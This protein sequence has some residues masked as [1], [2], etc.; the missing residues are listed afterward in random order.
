MHTKSIVV[1]LLLALAAVAAWFVFGSGASP[2]LP[3]AATPHVE[4]VLQAPDAADANTVGSTAGGAPVATDAAATE[5]MLVPPSEATVVAGNTYRVRGRLVDAQGSP[6]TN[7]RVRCH[8]WSVDGLVEDSKSAANPE[9]TSAADGVFAFDVPHGRN[10]S[11]TLADDDLVFANDGRVQFESGKGERD[12]GDLVVVRTARLKGVVQDELGRPVAGVIVDAADG[13]LAFGAVSRSKSGADG[14]FS[15]GKLRPGAWRVRAA[16]AQFL[17]TTLEVALAA[18]EQ[19]DDLVLVVRRGQAIAGQVVDDR[20]VGV[21]GCKVGSK[22]KETSGTMAIERFSADE[23]TTTDANGFFT[24]AGLGEGTATIRAFGAGHTGATAADVPIGTGNLVL[25]VQR[26]AVV[27]GVLVTAAGEPIAGS[28]VTAE[29]ERGGWEGID[30]VP[31]SDR[32]AATTA[33]D[34]TFRLESVEPGPVTLAARGKGHLP[35]RLA[36]VQAGPGGTVRGVRLVAEVGAEAHALVVD[37]DGRPVAG[38]SV[39]ARRSEGHQRISIGPS[40]TAWDFG[41]SAGS[42]TTDAEGRAT[43]T[44]LPAGETEFGAEHAAF[45]PAPKV[46]VAVPKTGAID[47]RLVLTKP[48]FADVDVRDLR[49]DAAVGREVRIELDGDQSRGSRQGKPAGGDGRVRFGPLAPGVY[50]AVLVRRADH[51]H[52]DDAMLSFDEDDDAITA[53]RQQFTIS[54]GATVNVELRVPVL[55]RLHGT[56]LGVDGPLSDCTVELERRD[57]GASTSFSSRTVR[58]G[59]DGVFVFDEVEAGSYTIAYGRRTQNVKAH[60]TVD[61]PSGAADVRQDL[62]LHTGRIVLGVREAGTGHAIE[63]AEVELIGDAAGNNVSGERS[64][65]IAMISSSGEGGEAMTVQIGPR[66]PRSDREGRVVIDDV[67]VGSYLVR[68]THDGHTSLDKAE[69]VVVERQTTD[70]GTVELVLAQPK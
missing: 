5:R 17:P 30:S 19:R 59:G 4:R 10:G 8:S 44:G 48:G 70:C 31:M 60:Q 14:T 9:A 65:M 66:P 55:A 2:G 1:V 23:A 33:A 16:S 42:A 39:A 67:P 37:E 6:R 36:G 51:K 46:I 24:L 49:G 50:T 20:N 63:G 43:V 3:Q 38:A 40:G 57:A 56:V 68:V 32:A 11:L 26:L 34:G 12:L 58:S 22:R 52:P 29:V 35:A 27:E 21:A 53:S 13:V 62:A 45:A 15:I 69:Q 41:E 28:K 61:V 47:V 64:M 7:A 54:S 18:G 25:Q